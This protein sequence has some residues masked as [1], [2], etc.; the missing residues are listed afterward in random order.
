MNSHIYITGTGHPLELE[1][2]QLSTHIEVCAKMQRI[3]RIAQTRIND[4]LERQ[5]I[6]TLYKQQRPVPATD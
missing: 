5:L 4:E 1:H 6:E 2:D 3:E